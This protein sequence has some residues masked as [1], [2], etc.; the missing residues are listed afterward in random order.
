MAKKR[1]VIP[2]KR[3][4][5]NP[6]VQRKQ[7][8]AMRER[9]EP[10]QI[11]AQDLPQPIIVQVEREPQE[12]VETTP[13]V[14]QV[15]TSV[16]A[17]KA[18]ETNGQSVSALSD[19]VEK[20]QVAKNEKQIDDLIDAI[21]GLTKTVEKSSQQKFYHPPQAEKPKKEE[22]KEPEKKEPEINSYKGLFGQIIKDKVGGVKEAVSIRN[23]LVKAGVSSARAGSGSVIDTMLS[24]RE[25][26]AMEEKEK[27]ASSASPILM[28][29]KDY[30]GQ[31]AKESFDKVKDSSIIKL[32]SAKVSDLKDLVKSKTYVKS[33]SFVGPKIPGVR[34]TVEK[35]L[36]DK[37]NV[38]PDSFLGMIAKRKIDRDYIAPLNRPS[39]K[40]KNKGKIPLKERV[41]EEVTEQLGG[42]S[43]PEMADYISTPAKTETQQEFQEGLRE[44]M[45]DELLKLNQ[46][47]LEELKKLVQAAQVDEE[48]LLEQ[49]KEAIAPSTTP[50]KKKD[51]KKESGIFDK[52][53]DLIQNKLGGVLGKLGPL[54]SGAASLATK[55]APL[56]AVAG[57]GMAGYWAGG[58]LNEMVL[59]PLAEKATGVKGETVGT[60]TYSAVDTVK[61]WFGASDEDK[62][63]QQEEKD[64]LALVHRAMQNGTEISPQL[65]TWAKTKGIEVPSKLIRSP[66][67]AS[68]AQVNSPVASPSS[69][70]S[71]VR[72]EPYRVQQIQS[73]KAS[74]AQI[75]RLE[76]T[77]ENPTKQVVN[78]PTNIVSNNTTNQFVR[79][80]LRPSEPSFNRLL[81][82]N[83]SH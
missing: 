79:P 64:K 67:T 37:A 26:K 13:I 25:A 3:L 18:I 48:A 42:L 80:Q 36:E 6:A 55:A 68:N 41:G 52:I 74:E 63:K 11:V 2:L 39:P 10:E 35:N 77:K 17:E 12:T 28:G 47:Q 71:K 15:E 14:V 4:L 61:G 33:E 38:S 24:F 75:E 43:E 53:G 56:A 49:K 27:K 5:Q 62:I 9:T 83:F 72:T 16:P 59:N 30:L 69:D 31:K 50:E 65:A 73:I 34:S 70:V 19:A 21:L 54:A 20:E 78:A 22:P 8:E 57:A 32:A 60:A 81:S 46:E 1:K 7:R 29:T 51:E 58:K 76:A 82:T 40:K 66:L 23:V 44:G 45:R